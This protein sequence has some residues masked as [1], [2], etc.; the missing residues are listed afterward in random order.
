MENM[1]TWFTQ[2]VA[3]KILEDPNSELNTNKGIW[4]LVLE[5]CIKSDWKDD[6]IIYVSDKSEAMHKLEWSKNI[7]QVVKYNP[8]YP[9]LEEL[10]TWIIRVLIVRNF[11]RGNENE[12][13]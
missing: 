6:D 11:E 12:A 7:M 13:R 10:K 8:L 1:R 2:R 4:L 9:K 3:V 5:S